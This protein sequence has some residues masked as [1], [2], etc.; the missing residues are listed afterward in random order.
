[1]GETERELFALLRAKNM[2][3]RGLCEKHQ[4]LD[5]KIGE[6]DRLYYLTS[7]QERK[8]KDLLQQKIGLK[9]QMYQILRQHN[10][11]NGRNGNLFFPS[12]R[13]ANLVPA[14]SAAD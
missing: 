8:R 2:I 1:M 11:A 13:A 12:A 4:A 6:Y 14:V 3:F 10:D 9:D 7:E 5:Q